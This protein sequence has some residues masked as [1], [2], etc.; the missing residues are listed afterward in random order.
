MSLE[1]L[2]DY[3]VYGHGLLNPR[4]KFLVKWCDYPLK[5]AENGNPR[6][7]LNLC[8]LYLIYIFEA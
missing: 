1:I 7:P 5:E 4:G 6:E 8:T 3:R 2:L